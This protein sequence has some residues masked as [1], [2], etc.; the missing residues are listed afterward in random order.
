MSLPWVEKFRPNRLEDIKGHKDVINV[1]QKYGGISSMPHLLFYGPPGTGKTSTILAMARESYGKDVKSM[2][3]EINASDDRGIDVIKDRVKNFCQSRSLFG[4][5]SV[6]LIILDEADALTSDAQSALRRI[7]EQYTKYVRFCIC[8]NYVG[9][10]SPALQSRCTRFRFEGISRE[11]L[12][13]KAT[14]IV[15]S[16]KINIEN[17]AIDSIIDL[18]DGDARRV[19]NLLQACH[20]SSLG[21]S[22]VIDCDHVYRSAGAPIPLHI[23]QIVEHLLKESFEVSF[24]MIRQMVEKYG[25]S[26]AD[27]VRCVSMKILEMD[28]KFDLSIVLSELSN[29]EMN[30]SKGGSEILNVGAL[31]SAFHV[32]DTNL[33]GNP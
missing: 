24:K 6:K 31:V 23:S 26:M 12:K 19:I 25:Y 11:S 4:V 14:E 2:V 15:L 13:Q 8:C 30:L 18:A 21:N 10:I 16:E 9:K 32:V 33:N 27:I 17:S 20:M 22:A 29:I 5:S 3:I 28:E 1:L 7:I